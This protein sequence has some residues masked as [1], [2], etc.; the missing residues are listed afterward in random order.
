MKDLSKIHWC[1]S[2]NLKKD[3][4]LS[5]YNG[6]NYYGKRYFVIHSK[7]NPRR[8]YGKLKTCSICG[9]KYF[10]T[11]HNIKRRKGYG[12]KGSRCGHRCNRKYRNNHQG[13]LQFWTGYKTK[14]AL[15]HIIVYVPDHPF[16]NTK[17][18]VS[19]HR[20]IMERCL[21]RY[22]TKKEQVYHINGILDDNR[23]ENLTLF[24]NRS[25]ENNPNWKGG[26]KKRDGYI[27]IWNPKHPHCSGKSYVLEHRLVMEK[28]LGRYLKPEERVHHKN[29]IKDDNRIE[30]LTLFK[31]IGEHFKFHWT[32]KKKQKEMSALIKL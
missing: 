22:L 4:I 7:K 15:G 16:C 21:G 10:I 32:Q 9:E 12:I 8:Y 14:T 17:G 1:P 27:L 26:R 19:E 31:N 25:G 5:D 24:R 29:G 6:K 28:H 13:F 3:Y 20:L 11:T 18:C 2:R 30:N 23:I